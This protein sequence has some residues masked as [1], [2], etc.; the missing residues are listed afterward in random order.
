[1]R[2]SICGLA[3]AMPLA[4]ILNNLNNSEIVMDVSVR[5]TMLQIH[6][7][8]DV[9]PA[10]GGAQAAL[11]SVCPLGILDQNLVKMGWN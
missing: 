9:K 2:P 8:G 6:R 7:R 10:A 3:L 4:W 1:M 11:V 5:Q